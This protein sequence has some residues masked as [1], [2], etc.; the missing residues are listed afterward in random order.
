M[1]PYLVL[2]KLRYGVFFAQ[3]VVTR[4]C[5]LSCAY[6]NE[7]DKVSDPVPKDIVKRRVDALH[8]LRTREL[9]LTGGECL[10]HPDL[11]EIVGYSS[12]RMRTTILSNAFLLTDKIVEGLNEA[13]LWKMQIS[14]D[15][16]SPNDTT[17]KVLKSLRRK[18]TRLAEKAKFEVAINSVIGA[19]PAEE[20]VEVAR[21]AESLGLTPRALI[22][23][24]GSGG[25]VLS[26]EDRAASREIGRVIGRCFDE[27]YSYRR[28]LIE[29]KKAP[30]K[31]RSG[32]RYLYVDEFGEVHW[33]S[34]Q[35]GRIGKYIEEYTWADLAQHFHTVK[36]CSPLCTIGCARTASKYDEW[37]PQRLRAV[38]V[39]ER[40][41]G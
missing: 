32:A 3:L 4:K 20:A 17:I 36:T 21:F 2:K 39:K 28:R 27:A 5:N 7:F 12:A 23:H 29:G 26:E 6:C 1:T 34:Q 38:R 24:D 40:H 30:F 19:A 41:M 14:V 9:S 31:C 37:R 13:G 16:V 33:C 8:G 10:L 25:C 35:R 15:G 11:L 22:I 18:L